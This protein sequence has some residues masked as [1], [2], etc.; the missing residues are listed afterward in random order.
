MHQLRYILEV[1][2]LLVEAYYAVILLDDEARIAECVDIS[3]DRTARHAQSL[4]DVVHRVERV[5]R[6]HLHQTQHAL[7][8][9]LVH[10]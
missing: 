8:L 10:P 2:R 5:G 7:N 1:R 6:K 3:V 4:G 9:G